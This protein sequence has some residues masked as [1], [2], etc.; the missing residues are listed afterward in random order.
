MRSAWKWLVGDWHWP[1]AALFAAGALIALFP[2]LA[3]VAGLP[4]AVVFLQLPLYMLHP[5]EEH[6]GDRF[7]WYVNRVVGGGREVL[8][9]ATTFWINALGV[10]GVDLAALYAAWLAGPPAGL[11]AG[12]LAVVNALLHLGP[13]I[14][15]REYN[16][17]LVTALV[18]LLPGGSWC[19]AVA[20]GTAGWPAHA[21]GLAVAVA[22]HLAIVAHVVRRLARRVS[23]VA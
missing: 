19:V 23:S 13:A 3:G 9:P 18:L 4:L 20:G 17:G 5:W 15:R 21:A 8:T 7:R 12:Y 1:A 10:W 22:L 11:A 2:L 16:P 14:R 6:A